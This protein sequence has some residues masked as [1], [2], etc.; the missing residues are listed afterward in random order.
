MARAALEGTL[1]QLMGEQTGKQLTLKLTMSPK[2]YTMSKAACCKPQV[3][4]GQSDYA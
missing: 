3:A 1:M 4:Q 2:R